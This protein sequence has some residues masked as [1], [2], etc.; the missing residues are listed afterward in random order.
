MKEVEVKLEGED[1]KV[2]SRKEYKSSLLEN[3]GILGRTFHDEE[4]G[5]TM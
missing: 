5:D 4:T 3:I 2:R 1:E